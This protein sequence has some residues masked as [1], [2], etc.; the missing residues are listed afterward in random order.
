[1][2]EKSMR[3]SS[4]ETGLKLIETEK[5]R[6]VRVIGTGHIMKVTG[7]GR[8]VRVTAKDH[9]ARVT[10]IGREVKV[11]GIGRIMRVTGT[12]HEAKAIV[13]MLNALIMITGCGT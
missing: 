12:G 5:D 6:V 3:A 2:K 11:T 1:M 10:G 13:S 4:K 9:E 7:T 8:I